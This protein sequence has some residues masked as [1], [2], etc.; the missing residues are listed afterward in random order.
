MGRTSLKWNYSIHE[1]K[2]YNL[3]YF[4]NACGILMF[5]LKKGDALKLKKLGF[6]TVYVI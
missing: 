4:S 6:K 5:S 2:P 3:F 1:P